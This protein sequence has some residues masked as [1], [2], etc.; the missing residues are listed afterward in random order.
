MFDIIYQD[1]HLVA[2][3]KPAGILVHRTQ[4]DAHEERVVL[5]LLSEQLGAHLY[6]VHRLDKA[7]S[8]ILLFA[9]SSN[10]ARLI[11]ASF[12]NHLINKTYIALVRGH[13]E[14]AG[15]IDH[16]LS[17]KRDQR[18][19]GVCVADRE[20]PGKPSQTSYRR[21]LTTE[22]PIA[23]GRYEKSRYSLVALFPKTG[24]RHQL[25]RHMKHIDHPIIGDTTYGQGQHNRLFRKHFNSH[26]LL[27]CASHL[28]FEHPVHNT[29]LDFSTKLDE[30][31]MG[32][33][34]ALGWSSSQVLRSIET[35]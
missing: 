35:P 17:N 16:A 34:N 4:L 8:G 26:R 29:P 30:D 18:R 22:V 2:I 23:C 10:T 12:E 25:R 14:T 15:D 21:L 9:L 19:E 31:F 33:A 24:R 3:H 7:T 6:P 28:A 20:W 5:Q 13:C 11:Q 32:V 1:D 27:L